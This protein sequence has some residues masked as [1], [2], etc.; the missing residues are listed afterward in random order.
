MVLATGGGEWND[1]QINKQRAMRER[2][3]SLGL[4]GLLGG[5]LGET[6]LL[7]ALSLGVNLV[8]RGAEEV[9]IVVVLLSGGGGGSGSRG[10]GTVRGVGLG[11]VSGE[12]LVLGR[13]RLDVLVPA[14]GVGI[15]GG[16][17][18]RREGLE[19]G[20]VGLRGSV[21]INKKSFRVG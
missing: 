2:R 5:V 12:R 1:G 9:D 4:V 15:G 20:N 19:D 18:G 13:V 17:R 8:V 3:C 7:D 21:S 11:G 6:L 10:R 14:S 16:G